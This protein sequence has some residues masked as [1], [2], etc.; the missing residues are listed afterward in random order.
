MKH[1]EDNFTGVDDIKIYYQS[2]SPDS[3]PKAVIQIIHGFGEH[4]GRYTNVVNELVPRGYVIYAN[5]HRGHG[6]SEGVQMYVKHFNDFVEDQKIFFDIIKEK[7]SKLPHFLLGHSMGSV[8]AELFVAK[9]PES[10]SGLVLSGVATH[11]KSLSGITKALAKFF[12]SIAPKMRMTVDLAPGLSRDVEVQKA[13]REDPLVFK[14][15]TMRLGA[16]FA[17]GIAN[18]KKILNQIKTPVLVQSGS[19]DPEMLGAEEFNELLSATDKSVK[20]YE[21]LYHEV[22][23]ELEEDRKIVLKDLGDWLDKH[24]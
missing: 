21:G 15:P 10:I 8:I 23:N 19:K 16:E 9:Y 24:V 22:Y 6:K 1:V 5:D 20:I 11:N 7:E 17:R 4:S 3:A 13:Y 2:W 18:A 14:N 12:G